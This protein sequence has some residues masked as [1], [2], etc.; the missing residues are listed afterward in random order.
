MYV[1][2]AGS[3]PNKTTYFRVWGAPF[4]RAQGEERGRAY[5]VRSPAE[6]CVEGCR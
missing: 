1:L 3:D 4:R 5:L 6:A 2:V